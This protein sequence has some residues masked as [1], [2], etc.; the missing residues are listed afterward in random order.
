MIFVITV[1]LAKASETKLQVVKTIAGVFHSAES[2]DHAKRA[3]LSTAD[4][5]NHALDGWVMGDI[6]ARE[7]TL[8]DLLPDDDIR[9]DFR[10]HFEL[11]PVAEAEVAKLKERKREQEQE[12]QL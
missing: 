5:I 10:K 2:A 6:A 8:S 11:A 7:I 9:E 4:F 1:T 3:M 12:G